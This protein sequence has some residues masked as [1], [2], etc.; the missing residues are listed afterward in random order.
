[1]KKKKKAKQAKK[2]QKPGKTNR[3]KSSGGRKNSLRF[4]G[5]RTGWLN[6]HVSEKDIL[7][8]LV[9]AYKTAF[10]GQIKQAEAMMSD[11]V[12]RQ[13]RREAEGLPARTE[14]LLVLARTLYATGK[15]DKA[16]QCYESA[17]KEVRHP[18]VCTELANTCRHQGRIADALHWVEEAAKLEPESS[19]HT[20]NIASLKMMLN[21]KSEA[22]EMLQEAV[23]KSPDIPETHSCLLM[24]LHYL[25]NLDPGILAAE[26]RRFGQIHLGAACDNAG[27]DNS[28]E[29]DRRLRVGYLSADYRTHSVM[30]FLE[31]LLDGHNTREFELYAYSD[32]REP[33]ETTRR[34]EQKFDHFRKIDG[35]DH[36]TVAETIRRDRIDIL[37][38]LS[39]HTAGNRLAVLAQKAAPVQVAYLGYPDST[40]LKQVDYRLTDKLAE[41][42]EAQK[43]YT[44]ELIYLPE[45]FLC[46]RPPG[47]NLPIAKPPCLQRGYVTFGSFNNNLKIN[48]L[49]L[50]LW[51]QVLK[52]VAGSRLLL[53]FKAAADASVREHYRREFERF[54]IESERVE[55]VGWKSRKQ[56]LLLYS[57]IDIALDTYPYQGTTTTCEA[58]WMGVPVISLL[59][60]HH[61]SRVAL[62]I[63]SRIG[64]E[65]FVARE[66]QEYISKAAALANNPES[67]SRIRAS[68]RSRMLGTSLCDPVRF[69][70]TVEEAYRNIWRKWCRS[71][72]GNGAESGCAG[73]SAVPVPLAKNSSEG[74]QS[75]M[76]AAEKPSA[77]GRSKRGVLYVTW[78]DQSKTQTSLQRSVQSVREHHPE[79]PIQIEN[80]PNG[81]KKDK[82]RMLSFTPFDETLYLDTDTVVLGRLDFAF[83]KAKKFGLACCINECP[84][85]R[86]FSDPQFKGDIVEYNSGVLFFNKKAKPVF[87]GWEEFFDTLDSSIIHYLRG[88]KVRQRVSDQAAFAMAVEKTGFLP[89]IL[90]LNWN[91][92]PIWHKSFFGPVKIW[93]DYSDLPPALLKWNENQTAENHVIQYVQFNEPTGVQNKAP[94][95][96][97]T[98]QQPRTPQEHPYVPVLPNAAQD[99]LDQIP[100]IFPQDCMIVSYPRSG[101]TWVR[102]LLANLIANA[103][104]PLNFAQMENLVPDIHEVNKWDQLRAKPPGRLIKSHM[105]YDP[106]YK[107]LI[108]IVRDGRDVAVSHYHYHC[109]HNFQAS[110]LQFLQTDVWPGPW[111]RHV[112]SWLDHADQPA[113]L[114]IRYEDL[115]TKPIDQL[116]RMAEFLA[117]PS[118]D[119]RLRQA[120]ENCSFNKLQDIENKR[121]YHSRRGKDFKFFRKGTN[122]QW[123]SYFEPEHKAIFKKHN[124]DAL[125]RLGYIDNLDW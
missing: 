20:A 98:P 2:K 37:V 70:A 31:S 9:K 122:G 84:W 120:V 27:F 54:G 30:Y 105:P 100:P 58:L 113:F 21:Q 60:R 13:I 7:P 65:F 114:L 81:S 35:M 79:L 104:Q 48:S 64:M 5:S 1:M 67:L 118:D 25:P 72:G 26:H 110:F 76:L 43:F 15:L 29:T 91:L 94:V 61:A 111:H 66:P 69:T 62:S 80:F 116:K 3:P 19:A 109:P 45:G 24:N 121:G 8:V 107:K 34:L 41:L 89:F 14:T 103:E 11:E 55:F 86:R 42:P 50:A 16:E 83:E 32:C 36:K 99:L 38:D 92:R 6:L 59:G 52:A 102:F 123:K 87:D 18:V 125:F 101:N 117:L 74:T 115:L 56:H 119:H 22:M 4:S 90:P 51:A 85:A 49:L 39:G 53:K 71:Q 10:A 12:I 17:M 33:D 108:Y 112:S 95:K 73:K 23:R 93:H 68:M 88:R 44:E 77:N 124:D 78:G 82:T 97:Q 28:T 75:R 57:S 96:S 40:G 47:C 46:Y 106:A 63:L